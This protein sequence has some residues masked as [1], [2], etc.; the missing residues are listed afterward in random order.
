MWKFLA[1]VPSSHEPNPIFLFLKD[2]FIDPFLA[3]LMSY[4]TTYHRGDVSSSFKNL[5]KRAW[6]QPK[7]L[8]QHHSDL[9][10]TAHDLLQ[11]LVCARSICSFFLFS[12]LPFFFWVS[13]E[14]STHAATIVFYS[15]LF[16]LSGFKS[17][18]I[19]NNNK[20]KT[21]CSWNTGRKV[22]FFFPAT[23]DH[24]AR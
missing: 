4:T 5:T 8:Y 3:H 6:K 21:T 17:S 15:H 19:N 22:F 13:S 18:L 10:S 7:Q 16:K 11:P 9:F 20:K 14:K 12:F 2:L 24:K 23:P 1:Q